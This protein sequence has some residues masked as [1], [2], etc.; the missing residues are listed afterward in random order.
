MHNIIG[1]CR[2]S[3]NGQ[4]DGNY[5]E[6]KSNKSL[7]RYFN[8]DIIEENYLGAKESPVFNKVLD[9]LKNDDTLKV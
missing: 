5:L 6:E 2:V 7:E 8:A 9:I 4:V 3:T 1:Y